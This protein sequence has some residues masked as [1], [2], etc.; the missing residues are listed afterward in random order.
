[1]KNCVS[2]SDTHTSCQ[3]MCLL[4]HALFLGSV[5]FVSNKTGHTKFPLFKMAHVIPL[6]ERPIM[7]CPFTVY[8]LRFMQEGKLLAH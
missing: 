7:S 1:M 8:P 4:P 3:I 6:Q 2:S 5:Y